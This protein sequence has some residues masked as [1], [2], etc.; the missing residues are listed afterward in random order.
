MADLTNIVLTNK[1]G[2]PQ[3]SLT[4]VSWAWFDENIGAMNAPTDKGSAETTDG[5]GQMTLA[6]PGSSLTSGQ[7]GTLV[8]YDRTGG[9]LAVYRLAVD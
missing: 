3:A 8:L 7:V 5:S 6:M 2:T 1:S 9:K 4:A